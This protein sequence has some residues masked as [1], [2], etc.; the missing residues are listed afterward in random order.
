MI[1]A[2]EMAELAAR[3]LITNGIG[4]L[5]VANRTFERA[6]ALAE[7]LN[8]T[9]VSLDDLEAELV[10]TDIVISSTASQGVVINRDDVERVMKRRR[11]RPVFF[12]DIAVPRDIDPEVGRVE[13][14]YLYDIDD[15]QAVVGENRKRR[16][17]ESQKALQI[18]EREVGQFKAW[19]REQSV[20]PLIV[21]LQNSGG[22]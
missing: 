17:K 8:G 19:M 18:I 20:I 21:S 3:H 15:L 16:A 2:G 10:R 6:R 12:I 5:V 4:R 13:N 11:H 14:I 7:E 9:P 1:G 22:R